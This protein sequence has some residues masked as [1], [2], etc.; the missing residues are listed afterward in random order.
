MGGDRDREKGDEGRR[1]NTDQEI[2]DRRNVGTARR[3][4]KKSEKMVL[5]KEKEI[6]K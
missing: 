4:K 1:K 6:G 2:I 5:Q 3:K